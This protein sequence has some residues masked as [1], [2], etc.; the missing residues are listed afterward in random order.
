MPRRIDRINE[1]LRSE[2]SHLIAREIKDPRVAGVISI[3]EVV[4]SND[5][6]SARVFVSVMGRH[7]DRQSALDGIR[8][9]ASFLRRELRDR[10]NLKHTPHLTFVL[11]DS[12]EEG[13]RILRLMDDF[14]PEEFA[15]AYLERKE[16]RRR[17]RAPD[18]T[19]GQ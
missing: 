19:K 10:V 6:R 11:D 18:G 3:T 15:A 17:V 16:P 7:S 4:A 9:A 8:S 2:I 13:D 12:I 14:T 5:L 1:L